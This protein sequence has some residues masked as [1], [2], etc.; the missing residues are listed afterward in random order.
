MNTNNK[1]EDKVK[2]VKRIKRDLKKSSKD[3][4]A[5]ARGNSFINEALRK[6]IK[7]LLGGNK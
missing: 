2:E 3:L 1:K 6:Q 4:I 5:K 7:K